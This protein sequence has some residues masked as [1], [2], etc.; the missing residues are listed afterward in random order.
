MQGIGEELL[1]PPEKSVAGPPSFIQSALIMNQ[2]PTH[3]T[4]RSIHL[5][6]D[7]YSLA[8]TWGEI[9]FGFNSVLPSVE[10]LTSRGRILLRQHLIGPGQFPSLVGKWQA[11]EQQHIHPLLMVAPSQTLGYYYAASPVTIKHDMVSSSSSPIYAIAN[12]DLASSSISICAMLL[13]Q[14]R[15]MYF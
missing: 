5:P 7:R 8:A 11:V 6:S 2:T 1:V 14:V 10:Q 3:N 13:Y 12:I 4:L 15:I 9:C